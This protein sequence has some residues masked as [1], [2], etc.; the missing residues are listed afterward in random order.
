MKPVMWKVGKTKDNKAKIIDNL[1]KMINQIE[2]KT[3]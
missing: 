1:N 2:L 3:F